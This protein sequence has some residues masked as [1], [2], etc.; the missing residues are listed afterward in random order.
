LVVMTV[1]FEG[2]T[3]TF[4]ATYKDESE[5]QSKNLLIVAWGS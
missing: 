1:R 3:T 2:S 5:A 4:N